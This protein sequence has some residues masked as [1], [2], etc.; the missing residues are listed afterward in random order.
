MV[1]IRF[2]FERSSTLVVVG[3]VS[4]ATV[5]VAPDLFDFAVTG[6][7]FEVGVVGMIS[8]SG[9]ACGTTGA[10]VGAGGGAAA[11]TPALAVTVVIIGF[12]GFV[13]CGLFGVVLV[14]VEVGDELLT[15]I[16][17][18]CGGCTIGV[19]VTAVVVFGAFD[20]VIGEVEVT[21]LGGVTTTLADDLFSGVTTVLPPPDKGMTFGLRIFCCLIRGAEIVANFIGLRAGGICGI[22]VL[23]GVIPLPPVGTNFGRADDCGDVAVAA[24]PALDEVARNGACCC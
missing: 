8:F 22:T 7:A 12:A 16:V 1:G 15:T 21:A 19:T 24:L 11:T 9:F 18:I 4:A 14:V 5:R 6:T 23:V 17:D 13:A 2:R 3:I 20:L 10:G